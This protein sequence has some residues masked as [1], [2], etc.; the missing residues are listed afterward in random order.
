MITFEIERDG[1]EFHAWSPE[2][3]G[4]HTHGRTVKEAL[5]NLKD[6]A[7][8]YLETVMEESIAKQ[9]LEIAI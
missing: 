5:R 9:T 1:T 7:G 4:C 2:L 6:A 8:L 3:P